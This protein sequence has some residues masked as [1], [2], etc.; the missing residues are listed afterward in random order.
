MIRR[1]SFYLKIMHT[2]D[3]FKAVL[4]SPSYP[5]KSKLYK[6]KT[7]VLF[8]PGPLAQLVEQRPFKAWVTGSNP[9]RLSLF[10]SPSSSG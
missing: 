1:D 9:V 7:F 5:E 2:I 8:I 10:M 6:T 4:Y 3:I